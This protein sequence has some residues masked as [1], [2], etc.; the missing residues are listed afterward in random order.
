MEEKNIQIKNKNKTFISIPTPIRVNNT[1]AS[2]SFVPTNEFTQSDKPAKQ[3]P[4]MN[5]SKSDNIPS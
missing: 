5:I 1:I 3:V 2:K 4:Y